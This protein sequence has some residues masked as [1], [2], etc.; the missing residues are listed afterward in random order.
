V[1]IQRASLPFFLFTTLFLAVPFVQA[2]ETERQVEQPVRQAI[3][4]RQ[5]AQKEV[6]Q[7]RGDKDRL[8][9]RF[10]LLQQETK[11]LKTRSEDLQ[12]S[13]NAAEGRLNGKKQQLVEIART[14]GEIAPFLDELF[15]QLREV[16]SQGPPFLQNER[17]ARIEK[18][19]TLVSDPAVTVGEKYRRLMEALLV[20]AE[21]GFTTEVYQEHIALGSNSTLVDVFRLG[22]LNLFYLTLDQSRCGFYNEAAKTWEPLSDAHLRTIKSAVAIAAKRQPA[23][24][25]SL[26]LGR[27][28]SR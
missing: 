10:E 22:R 11:D 9:A 28:A 3:D 8:T 27:M 15:G 25:L 16:S 23:E 5:A 13:V 12:A 4:A 1:T 20:E 18:L 24:L 26:P 19:Q 7:W 14:T 6:D 17:Q 21:Y 2:T